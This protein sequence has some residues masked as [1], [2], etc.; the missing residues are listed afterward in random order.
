MAAVDLGRRIRHTSTKNFWALLGTFLGLVDVQ[1]SC[2][3]SLAFILQRS[4]CSLRYIRADWTWQSFCLGSCSSG[5]DIR[6]WEPITQG[7][8]VA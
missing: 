3:G 8:S 6:H 4:S 1:Q 2:T 5:R 7:R